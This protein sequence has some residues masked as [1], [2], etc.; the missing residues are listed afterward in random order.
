[1]NHPVLREL[2]ID[3]DRAHIVENGLRQF[4]RLI[5]NRTFLLLFVRSIDENKYLLLKDR[6]YV[7]SLLMVI[8]Q[9]SFKAKLN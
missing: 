8:L 7:G 1:M 2:S 3:Q 5:Q 6:V 9:V 4:H